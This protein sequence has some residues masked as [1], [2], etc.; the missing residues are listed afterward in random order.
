LTSKIEHMSDN[1]DNRFCTKGNARFKKTKKTI[2]PEEKDERFEKRFTDEAFR[3]GA[4]VDPRGKKKFEDDAEVSSESSDSES[5][6]EAPIDDI[7]WECMDHDAPRSDDSFKRI[8][9]MGLDWDS[10]CAEDILAVC[11]STVTK[12]EAVTKVMI[13]PSDIGAEKL[14]KERT[15]GPQL[16]ISEPK[17]GEEGDVDEAM[18]KYNLERSKYYYGV[19]FCE[20][21]KTAE[22]LYDELDG[23]A[24]PCLCLGRPL[25]VRF[26]PEDIDFPHPHTSEATKLTRGYT[27]SNEGANVRSGTAHSKAICTWDEP[28][29]RR[30]KDLMKKLTKKEME[31]NDLAVYLASDSEDD[32]DLAEK[33]NALLGD[34]ME[35]SDMDDAGSDFFEKSDGEDEKEDSD[36]SVKEVSFTIKPDVDKTVEEIQ[37]KVKKAQR[38]EDVDT[39]KSAWDQYLRRKKEKKK[40]LRKK[41]QEQREG[42]EEPETTEKESDNEEDA[43]DAA[44]KEELELLMHDNAEDRDFNLKKKKK[45]RK[46][47][48]MVE[49][50]EQTGFKE[51]VGDARL[52]SMFDDPD[53]AIDPTNPA[54]KKT[55]IMDKFLEKTRDRK[56]NKKGKVV[57]KENKP[58]D[59]GKQTTMDVD[60]QEEKPDI[61]IFG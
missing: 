2:K 12:P 46:L 17:E 41:R 24:V 54:F 10:L 13:F 35:L 4:R 49:Q 50:A 33:R 55:K 19:A 8:A 56:K 52:Q 23:I 3:E 47:G 22:A 20:D 39:K 32:G 7:V 38:G 29:P 53:F 25:D 44:E 34:C 43:K 15:S 59:G 58:E 48:E 16:D 57:Q 9:F 40:E 6:E 45:K 30:K 37:E 11:R 1:P 14:E 18:R 28:N 60:A 42:G 26:I 36:D 31:E 27:A 61:K 51:N 21:I 5:E